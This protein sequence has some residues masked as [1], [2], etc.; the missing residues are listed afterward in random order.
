MKNS[1]CSILFLSF[2]L[3]F[4]TN[5]FAQGVPRL[6]W[7][8]QMGGT[9]YNT[10]EDIFVDGIGNV[11]T[12]GLFWGTV[13][14]D[15][16][17]ATFNLTSAG[18]S[19]I[20][21][22][23][24][25]PSGALIWAVRMGGTGNDDGFSITVDLNGNVLTT[26]HFRNTVDF[27]PGPGVFNLSG[28]FY[29]SFISKLDASGNFVWA[30]KFG[31]SSNDQNGYSI[32]VD[33]AGNVYT[34]GS[35]INTVDFDPGTGVFN[36]GSGCNDAY[37]SKLSPNGDFIWA[38]RLGGTA[39]SEEGNSLLVD[40]A[41]NVFIAGRFGDTA[42]FDPNAGTFNLTSAG[43]LDVFVCKLDAS[44]NFAWAKQ[45]GGTSGEETSSMVMDASGNLVI[46]GQF[47]GTADFDP[48]AGVFSLS[49]TGAFDVFICKL[50]NSGDFLWAKSMG[51]T[52]G[53]YGHD[54]TVDQNG[55]VFT[56][57]EFRDN[58][59][60]DPGTAT[61]ILNGGT[62][63]G[64]V[65]KL[66]ASGNFAWAIEIAGS[67]FDYGYGIT[68]D[69]SE[70]V[71]S[72]GS[73]YSANTDFD[74]TPCPFL[75]ASLG[76]GDIFI[77]KLSVATPL[78]PL[79]TIASFTPTIGPIGAT[80][81]ITGTNFSTTPSENLVTFFNNQSATVTASTTSN[82]TVTVPTGTTTG[83]I[84]VNLNCITVQ[85]ATNFTV[86]ATPL[87]TITSF[88]PTSGQ[89]GT[90]VTITGTN[91]DTTPSNN[92]VAFNGTTAVVTASTA[93]SITT[94][95]PTGA[96]TGKITVSVAGNT[97]T[98]ASDFTITLPPIVPGLEWALTLE[99]SDPIV[100]SMTTDGSGNVYTAG[101]FDGTVDFDPR[102]GVFNLTSAGNGDAFVSKLSSDG[103]L[104]WAFRLGGSGNEGASQIE[105]DGLGNIYVTGVI[106]LASG[107]VDFDPGAGI[108]LFGPGA[109]IS[110]F[111]T[112]GNLLWVRPLSVNVTAIEVDGAND[113]Y[114]GGSFSSTVDFDPGASVFNL[115]SAGSSD[116]FAL[117][118][119]SAGNFAWAKRIGG[120]QSDLI[121]SLA[122]DATG[123]LCATGVFAL[124]VDFDPDTGTANLTATG[125][126]DIFILK[127]DNTGN[128]VWARRIGS[129]SGEGVGGVATDAASNVLITGSYNGTLDFDPGAGVANLS[130]VA[131]L[132]AFVLKLNSAGNYVWAK[133]V[134]GSGSDYGFSITT[135]A[136]GDVYYTGEYESTVDFDPGSG[137]FNITTGNYDQTFVSKLDGSGNF[138]WALGSQPIGTA[139]AYSPEISLLPSNDIIV[140]GYIEDGTIDFNPGVCS[141]QLT[142]SFNTF[143]LKLSLTA[144]CGPTI[145]SFT[146]TSGPTGTT[147]T[148]T[149]TNFS[150][151]PANN[152]VQFNGTTAVVTASTATS[153][154]TSV[155]SG[156]T[157]GTIT[158]TVAGN[159]AT[160][161]SNF[162]VTA[163]PVIN[164]NIQPS[165]T[166]VCNGVTTSFTTAATGTT[167]ITYQWQFSTTVA[168]TYTD[169]ANG[170]GYSNVATASLAV[171]TSGN[172]GA[173][174]YRCKIN[175]DLAAN[176]FS[177]AVELIVHSIPPVPTIGTINLGCAPISTTLNPTGASTG[178][179]YKFFDAPTGGN[180][181]SSGLSFTTPSLSV[182]TT[183]HVSTYN[184]ATLCESARSPAVVNVQSCNPP[185][186]ETT[187]TTAFIEGIVTVELEELISDLDNN[188]DPS[189][190]QITIQ[191]ASGAPASLS[192][193]TLTIDYTGIPFPG[194]DNLEIEICDL[195]GICT[196]QDL[197]IQLE[198]DIEV[199]NAVSPNNDGSND[200]F[201]I[202]YIELF[203]DTE[204]NQV[205]IYNRWGDVVWE[206]ANYNNQTVVFDGTDKNG[207]E[208]PSGTY[209]FKIDFS[210]SLKSKTGFL[211]LKR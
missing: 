148:I 22:T 25:D 97:A 143:I 169:I 207:N 152:T 123:N 168:G 177:N 85:S 30:V 54:I 130:A 15:P 196:Q 154:T 21:V 74:P 182:T 192:G 24:Q 31:E 186:V 35:Y 163:G 65:S 190:L 140:A 193:F 38:K 79:H 8:S 69:A 187:T 134:G 184:T 45:M 136:S 46:T 95:V 203:T 72:T 13:D 109:Y 208:L 20:F 200:T 41:G 180:L 209:F 39:C 129:A 158:V 33:A 11:Y 131:S 50:N 202:E 77:Q 178:E 191:P 2:F 63:D 126:S 159:T 181:L 93:T 157:T 164:I 44:G 160:S 75:M 36:L 135:D 92:T 76:S 58:V 110:K 10:G 103:N 67:G 59:D 96:T 147:V 205:T 175:G 112:N 102:S 86:G 111:D 166:A 155:P 37:V 78:P 34:T 12:T 56:I 137:T 49:S 176:V 64:F 14:F 124:T 142:G 100:E 73:F 3:L 81:N 204:K 52:S 88:T 62:V 195:T 40:A 29:E 162:T 105:V 94:S 117:K 194:T 42:D 153:I 26:G 201:T 121:R 171:I 114:I 28:G 99:G 57:G 104:S 48:G 132:D 116:I 91:F 98:S 122:I 161:A 145:S 60:F 18:T 70:N 118:L 61:F 206:G 146:P 174:F 5:T 53:D 90:T 189:T 141:G 16:G 19:D 128:Y 9:G 198:G 172:F 66:D 170:S 6:A 119:T 120:T 43:S 144:T 82:L 107:S 1:P 150:T 27:D 113:V 138:L 17:P 106:N 139:Y 51:G 210:S 115:T 83:R 127:L 173:G 183:Y 197:T 47:S 211:S 185:V 167:N 101:Q 68:V 108:S 125:T 133:S 179:Q 199:F 149:G 32:A 165:S 151:S 80:V 55:N 188:L 89:V 23:K 87:P 156:A 4:A 7:A 71:Y 84:S